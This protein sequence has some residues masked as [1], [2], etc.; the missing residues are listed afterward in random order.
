MSQN[1]SETDNNNGKSSD[2][3]A[4]AM[5]QAVRQPGGSPTER[6]RPAKAA[7]SRRGRVRGTGLGTAG[8]GDPGALPGSGLGIPEQW[9]LH[10]I[11]Q[12]G[13]EGQGGTSSGPGARCHTRGEP[14]PEPSCVGFL[15][16]F[17]STLAPGTPPHPEQTES[18]DS[19]STRND[20]VSPSTPSAPLAQVGCQSLP[21]SP[22]N[23]SSLS[24][25]IWRAGLH[26]SSNQMF[27]A[28]GLGGDCR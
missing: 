13:V 15:F 9:L 22:A 23:R 16:L 26:P 3:T 5:A 19:A 14:G 12:V 17:L 2:N 1:R 6:R 28:E 25:N 10:P 20:S 24:R 8:G 18:V 27:A 7:G 21:V 11:P 4:V